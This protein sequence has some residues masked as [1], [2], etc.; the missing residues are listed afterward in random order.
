MKV[1]SFNLTNKTAYNSKHPNVPICFKADEWDEDQGKSYIKHRLDPADTTSDKVSC[2]YYILKGTE[3]KE[4][5][6]RW[7]M[8]IDNK[9]CK[10]FISEDSRSNVIIQMMDNEAKNVFNIRAREIAIDFEF[11]RLTPVNAQRRTDDS[12]NAYKLTDDFKKAIRQACLNAIR[13]MVFGTGKSGKY[14]YVFQK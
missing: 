4:L 13:D 7:R 3:S 11:D 10:N 12:Y 8:D 14:A 5:Y 2:A 1:V 9:V 6:V